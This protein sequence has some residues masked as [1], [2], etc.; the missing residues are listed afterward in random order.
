MELEGIG[1]AIAHPEMVCGADFQSASTQVRAKAKTHLP[2]R[3]NASCIQPM[4]ET[5]EPCFG[6]LQHDCVD[7]RMVHL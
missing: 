2:P 7:T 4:W 5:R 1:V 3:R 6:K